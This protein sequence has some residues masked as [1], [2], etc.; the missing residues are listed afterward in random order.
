MGAEGGPGVTISGLIN[1]GEVLGKALSLLSL[2]AERQCFTAKWG[3]QSSPET[4]CWGGEVQKR[5]DKVGFS[6][7]KDLELGLSLIRI[8]GSQ[9]DGW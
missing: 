4:R 7:L 5:K 9:G 2:K 1:P 6:K 3:V 8:A